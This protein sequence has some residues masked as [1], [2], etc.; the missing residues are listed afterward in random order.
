ML[1]PAQSQHVFYIHY[2]INAYIIYQGD[3]ISNLKKK[4]YILHD[5]ACNRLVSHSWHL[6]YLTFLAV[7]S[8]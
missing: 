1:G 4:T 7:D 6:L 2:L 3:Q 8:T 5:F